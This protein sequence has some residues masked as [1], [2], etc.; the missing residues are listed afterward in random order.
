MANSK[1]RIVFSQINKNLHL[2]ISKYKEMTKVVVLKMIKWD[3][4][5]NKRVQEFKLIHNKVKNLH[6]ALNYSKHV[7]KKSFKR[8]PIMLI[9]LCMEYP[10][11][12]N[13]KGS[14]KKYLMLR[15]DKLNK[16][17]YFRK[18]ICQ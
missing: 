18:L 17:Q 4:K 7:F 15:I 9:L 2:V 5:L 12:R 8:N 10:I 1:T 14:F 16:V 6:K 11:I 13:L 3:S